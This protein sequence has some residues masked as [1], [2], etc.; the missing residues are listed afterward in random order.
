RAAAQ[1]QGSLFP[2]AKPADA[3]KKA[4]APKK[5]TTRA[6]PRPARAQASGGAAG[7]IP[8]GTRVRHSKLGVGTLLTYE[9]DGDKLRYVVYF[10]GVGRRKLVAKFAKLDIVR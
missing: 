10:D 3:P 9:G 6:A 5:M 2:E 1:R 7:A 8:K 4:A